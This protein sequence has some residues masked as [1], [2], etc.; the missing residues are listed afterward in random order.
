[1]FGQSE[2]VTTDIG[3]DCN[4]VLTKLRLKSK[5]KMFL[6]EFSVFLD[7]INDMKNFFLF[8]DYNFHY[9]CYDTKVN[10]LKRLLEEHN[11]KQLVQGPT[12][13]QGHTLDLVLHRNALQL[14][15]NTQVEDKCISDHYVITVKTSIEKCSANKTVTIKRDIK[16]INL[17]NFKEDISKCL[18]SHSASSIDQLSEYLQGVLNK[19]APMEE[20]T[21]STRPIAPWMSLKAKEAKQEKRRAERQWKKSGLTVHKQIYTK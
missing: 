19:H 15:L 14:T 2:G 4:P 7:S 13:Q 8:G 5:I 21:I 20:K 10:S 16:H 6:D 1:M 9:E 11:I 12:H 17:E 3:S 18:S